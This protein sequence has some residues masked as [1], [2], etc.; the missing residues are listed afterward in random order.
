[1][2]AVHDSIVLEVPDG[3]VKEATKLLQEVMNRSGDEIL[4]EIPCLTEVKAGKNWSLGEGEKGSAIM[5]FLRR[6]FS[7]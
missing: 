7:F 2:N 6:I 5:Q 1:V 3:S 4:R